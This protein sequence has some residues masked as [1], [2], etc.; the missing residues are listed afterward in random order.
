MLGLG[1]SLVS[2]VVSEQM[3]SL[4]LDGTG[5]YL[6]IGDNLDL[7]TA[8]FSISL[9]TKFA[10]A[11]GTTYLISKYQS[12][13]Y[14]VAIFLASDDK[15]QVQVEGDDNSVTNN[16]GA[17]V[18]TPLENSWVHIVVTCNRDGN[19]ALYVNGATGTYGFS[20]SAGSSS[21]TLNNTASWIIGAKNDSADNAFTGNID[22]VA[23]FN[24]ELDSTNVTAIRNSGKPFNLNYDRGGYDQSS[25]LQGYW[26]MFN[27]PFD[28]LA[29]G[30]VHDAHNPGFGAELTTH[31]DFNDSTAAAAA[32]IEGTGWSFSDN[33]L[34][35]DGSHANSNIYQRLTTQY[36][37]YKVTFTVTAYTSGT[38]KSFHGAPTG[39]GTNRTAIGTYTD[40]LLAS[41]STDFIGLTGNSF[42]GEVDNISIVQL[43]GYPGITAADATFSTDTP[44]D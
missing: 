20:T 21:Q 18:V 4:L 39:Y 12:S 29:N 42:V 40:Y 43:N 17:A 27:G 22:E 34:K 35:N 38:V 31:G 23:I 37:T 15:I 5:D 16:K 6:D 44:D 8:D 26:R 24:T 19:I 33:V 28:D 3:Y 36:K 11:T 32:W 41:S 30:A 7:G 14:R 1:N 13:T 10:D 25:A 9:W 2:G